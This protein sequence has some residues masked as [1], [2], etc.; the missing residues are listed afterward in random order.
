MLDLYLWC[1]QILF[2]NPKSNLNLKQIWRMQIRKI[3]I[4]N[5]KDRDTCILGRITLAG[6]LTYSPL[7][8]DRAH[9]DLWAPA[10]G[11][12]LC[13]HIVARWG[14]TVNSSS[15]IETDDLLREAGARSDPAALS[16]SLP[17]VHICGHRRS[18]P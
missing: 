9:A 8:H 16:S 11:L 10:G 15:P 2:L 4:K 13:T 5:R 3:K 6:P 17:R 14:R 18:P 1:T 7:A 12:S